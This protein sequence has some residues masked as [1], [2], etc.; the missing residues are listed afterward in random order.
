MTLAY[1]YHWISWMDVLIILAA[2]SGESTRQGLYN[3]LS[4]PFR[5]IVAIRMHN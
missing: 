4:V 1:V 5:F 3:I 2:A